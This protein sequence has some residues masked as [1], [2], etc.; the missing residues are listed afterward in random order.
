[1]I[2][3][4]NLSLELA[5]IRLAN[6]VIATSGTFGYGEEFERFA[7]LRRIGGLCVKGTSAR[8]IDGKPATFKDSFVD[9]LPSSCRLASEGTVGGKTIWRVIT[10]YHRLEESKQ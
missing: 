8:L 10:K 3:T 9:I 4:V 6:P 1:M 5:G 7:D 2:D